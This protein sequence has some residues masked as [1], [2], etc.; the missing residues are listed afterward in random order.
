MIVK[1]RNPEDEIFE[2][3][4]SF[5]DYL[6][7]YPLHV[8]KKNFYGLIFMPEESENDIIR[9][10]SSNFFEI[11]DSTNENILF[12]KT[13]LMHQFYPNEEVTSKPF[14]LKEGYI[15]F[16]VTEDENWKGD[17][18][19]EYQGQPR[20]KCEY[21][22]DNFTHDL[23]LLG[24]IAAS[25]EYL[26]TIEKESLILAINFGY[27]VK[28]L[29]DF[30]RREIVHHKDEILKRWTE[31][32]AVT[33]EDIEKSFVMVLQRSARKLAQDNIDLLERVSSCACTEDSPFTTRSFS[34]LMEIIPAK[35][36]IYSEKSMPRLFIDELMVEG[37]LALRSE[38]K[39]DLE[40]NI[41]S[42][43][44]NY[45][46]RVT[47]IGGWKDEGFPSLF[48]RYRFAFH[49][50]TSSER[51][52]ISGLLDHLDELKDLVLAALRKTDESALSGRLRSKQRFWVRSIGLNLF[53]P[54]VFSSAASEVI[55]DYFSVF[56]C[57]NEIGQ[58]MRR[59]LI[60]DEFCLSFKLRYPI[61]HDYQISRR[62]FGYFYEIRAVDRLTRQGIELARK[63]QFSRSLRILERASHAIE[64]DLLVW[65]SR[66]EEDQEKTRYLR[67][68]EKHYLL[69]GLLSDF[70]SDSTIRTRRSFP[71]K[72][73]EEPL[74]LPHLD[75]M[76]L[77]I[78]QQD[79]FD[80]KIAVE[81]YLVGKSMRK[82]TSLGE[83]KYNNESN[84]ERK[85]SN[86][87]L[88]YSGLCAKDSI[89]L[90]EDLG[91]FYGRLIEEIQKK[92]GDLTAEWLGFNF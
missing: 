4:K 6:Q 17:V 69:A 56:L 80:W 76:R 33:H 50:D 24:T 58:I 67:E 19:V 91:V 57:K 48:E 40:Q 16:F 77:L 60:G 12:F 71:N 84:K 45:P 35:E 28:D 23:N 83:S 15:Y 90:V 22:C 8:G 21:F 63:H 53:L 68:A 1:F 30:Q 85:L 79:N 44:K 42:F 39:N 82:D 34:R 9:L 46:M 26:N 3:H 49:W 59:K 78:A 70:E 88:A 81:S 62:K 2:M 73:I 36:R 47:L 75:P 89:C 25:S 87:Y 5:G 54:T 55:R 31:Y 20:F 10:F 32:E 18:S 52:S 92:F 7:F 37:I 65:K 14:M 38:K 86:M 27:P 29:A 66:L 51:V 43:L 72:R 61:F 13:K 64:G 11:L 74:Y 41:Y